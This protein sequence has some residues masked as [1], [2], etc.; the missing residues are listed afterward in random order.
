[1]DGVIPGKPL[2]LPVT[3]PF[4]GE[5]QYSYLDITRENWDEIG[6]DEWIILASGIPCRKSM[7]VY[8]WLFGCIEAD[9]KFADKINSYQEGDS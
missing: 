2:P 7:A 9:A 1:M 3:S 4:N 8:S 5:A 6:E